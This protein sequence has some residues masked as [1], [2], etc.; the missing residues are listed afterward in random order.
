[1]NWGGTAYNLESS[2]GYRGMK[3]AV[4]ASNLRNREFAFPA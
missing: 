1:M 3:I 2:Q 4:F